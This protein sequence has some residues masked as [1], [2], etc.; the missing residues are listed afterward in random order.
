MP[1]LP[2]SPLDRRQLKPP[3]AWRLHQHRRSCRG[4]AS[5]AA[6]PADLPEKLLCQDLAFVPAGPA[7]QAKLWLMR[8]VHHS[9]IGPALC[10]HGAVQSAAL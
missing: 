2:G 8:S 7:M 6:L 9:S 3:C 5:P 1:G 10:V 4:R